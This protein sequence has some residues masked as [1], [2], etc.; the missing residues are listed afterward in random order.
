MTPS[1]RFCKTDKAW[2]MLTPPA[3][4]NR[5]AHALLLLAN[6]Q[7]SERE[8]SLLL[9]T[10]VSGLAR[11]LWAQGYLQPA[12]QELVDDEDE[13]VG[14]RWPLPRATAPQPGGLRASV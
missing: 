1:E 8:L 12:T 14:T 11:S 5:A 3:R 13:D 7:R 2:A 10:D 4:I 9:G 6:G